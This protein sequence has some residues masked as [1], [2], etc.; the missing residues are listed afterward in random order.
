[1][2]RFYLKSILFRKHQVIHEGVVQAGKQRL[3]NNVY[4][5]Q[6]LSTRGFGGV[7]PSHEFLANPPTPLQVPSE[8]T[9]VSVNNLFRLQKEDGSLV[10]TVVT[11]G[12]PGVGMSVSVAKFSLD[13]AEQRANRVRSE[14]KSTFYT[15]L[16][17]LKQ[18]KMRTKQKTKLKQWFNELNWQ[19]LD[20]AKPKSRHLSTIFLLKLIKELH[21]GNAFI[22]KM[23]MKVKADS[24][25]SQVDNMFSSSKKKIKDYYFLVISLIVVSSL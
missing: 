4:V 16:F 17:L 9:F 11:T 25:D 18:I 10:R 20:G 21:E 23:W 7:D 14:N 8:D 19:K 15:L 24:R 12:I 22:L 1:M 3:L 2:L 13:W 5:E 6:Q